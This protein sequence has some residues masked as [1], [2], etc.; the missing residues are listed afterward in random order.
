MRVN[1]GTHLNSP[2]CQVFVTAYTHRDFACVSAE[3]NKVSHEGRQAFHGKCAFSR[4]L[5]LPLGFGESCHLHIANLGPARKVSAT[6]WL[7]ASWKSTHGR[8]RLACGA[9]REHGRVGWS[10]YPSRTVALP[11]FFKE[12]SGPM[13]MGKAAWTR[14]MSSIQSPCSA[15]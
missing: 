10:W 8:C 4:G 15:S 7:C 14:P 12:E 9:C 2:P 5:F 1:N 11:S 3:D 6:F 13:S